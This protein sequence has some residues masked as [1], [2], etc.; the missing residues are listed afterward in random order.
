[1][2]NRRNNWIVKCIVICLASACLCLADDFAVGKFQDKE[3]IS[4][5]TVSPSVC[6]GLTHS[7]FSATHLQCSIPCNFN[8]ANSF[9]TSFQTQRQNGGG[10]AKKGFTMIKAGKSMNEYSTSLFRRSIVKFPSGMNEDNH[11]LIALRKLI[12]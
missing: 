5:I 3:V 7:S 12:I 10:S 6:L 8:F 11:H 1:M 9:R 2:K 4:D